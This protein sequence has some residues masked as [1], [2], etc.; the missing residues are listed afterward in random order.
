MDGQGGLDGEWVF[1]DCWGW[2]RERDTR[3]LYFHVVAVTLTG[4][5]WSYCRVG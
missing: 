1:L 5:W 2:E 4:P 3:G